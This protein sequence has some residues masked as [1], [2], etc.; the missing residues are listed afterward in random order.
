MQVTHRDL[1]RVFLLN[2]LEGTV[3]V[4]IH[5]PRLTLGVKGSTNC[6]SDGFVWLDLLQTV[7][8]CEENAKNW[9]M[10]IGSTTRAMI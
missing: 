2:G 7:S 4:F 8:V 1:E 10:D 3:L 5:A 6:F 9:S